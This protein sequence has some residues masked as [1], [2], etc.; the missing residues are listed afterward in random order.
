MLI[1]NYNYDD[2]N[3]LRLNNERIFSNFHMSPTQRDKQ[4][5]ILVYLPV[6]V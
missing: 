2:D 6:V 4:P 1:L 5:V 3:F